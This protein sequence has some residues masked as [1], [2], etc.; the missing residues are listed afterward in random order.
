VNVKVILPLLL[1]RSWEQNLVLFSSKPAHAKRGALF[2]MFP[3]HLE[4]DKQLA[5]M[6][7]TIYKTRHSEGVVALQDMRL[8][9]NLRTAAHLDYLHNMF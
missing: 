3:N 5:V 6:I 8:A 4:L 1:E 9:V 7:E 2:S